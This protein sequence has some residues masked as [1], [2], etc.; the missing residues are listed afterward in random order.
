MIGWMDG[1]MNDMWTGNT[2]HG[3]EDGWMVGWM[4]CEQE[5]LF[6]DDRMDGC[7]PKTQLSMDEK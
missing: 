7:E 2:F 4:G 6:M 1:W 5:T 3:W